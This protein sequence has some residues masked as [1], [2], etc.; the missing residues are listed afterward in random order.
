[1]TSP[2]EPIRLTR[3]RTALL[4]VPAAA[5]AATAATALRSEPAEARPPAGRVRLRRDPGSVVRAAEVDVATDPGPMARGGTLVASLASDRFGLVALTWRKGEAAPDLQLRVRRGGDWRPWQKVHVLHDGPNSGNREADGDREGSDLVWARDADAVQVRRASGRVP[6]GLRVVLID[7]GMR[8]A[9]D[10]PD[11]PSLTRAARRNAKGRPTKP[12][13]RGRRLWGADERL[14]SGRP[15]YCNRLQQVHLH[16]TVN[17]ND[18]GKKDV[19]GLIRGMYRYHTQSLGWSDIGYNFLVD[20]F[21]RIWVGRKGGPTK[22]VRGAHTLGFNH[23]SVGIAVIGNMEAGRPSDRTVTAIVMLA[24]WKLRKAGKSPIGRSKVRSEGSDR[25]APGRVVWLPRIDGHRD[26]NETACPGIKLY[27]RL[28]E[29][30]RRAQRRWKRGVKQ[31]R[32]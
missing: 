20:R 14:T 24:A 31:N 29:I 18:Y 16:H 2:S 12:P 4:A 22:L 30:R 8:D 25:F 15:S 32:G 11:S 23:T 27:N 21:G 5:A 7:P 6:A 9:D 13:L 3:R 19:P 17:A 1:M 28:P 10:A 26:T